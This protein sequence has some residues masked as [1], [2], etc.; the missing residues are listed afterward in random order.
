MDVQDCVWINTTR[1]PFATRKES[2]TMRKSI[3]TL[4]FLAGISLTG[5]GSILQEE[6]VLGQ[7]ACESQGGVS[8]F[9]VTAVG[10][11]KVKCNNRTVV[12]GELNV[13]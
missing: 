1:S 2:T 5:C 3:I 9:I 12:E 7:K 11:W 13:R 8:H 6:V 4:A 10:R